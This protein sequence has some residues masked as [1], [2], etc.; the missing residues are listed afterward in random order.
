MTVDRRGIPFLW[1]E[2]GFRTRN[3]DR[4]ST[5]RSWS[6]PFTCWPERFAY[7]QPKRISFRAI[8]RRNSR[9]GYPSRRGALKRITARL[10]LSISLSLS[11]SSA[12]AA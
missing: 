4:V 7:R 12:S 9:G 11:L 5:T 1:P 6:V 3:T 10:S 2:F 8:F